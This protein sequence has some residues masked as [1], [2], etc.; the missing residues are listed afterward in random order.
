MTRIKRLKQKAKAMAVSLGHTPA[1]NF[2]RYDSDRAN[3]KN[4]Y[5]HCSRCCASIVI[6]ADD[7]VPIWGGFK[8]GF[9]KG[10]I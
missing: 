8:Q 1:S 9:C 7:P 2:K 3:P 6:W 10:H 5:T 4:V